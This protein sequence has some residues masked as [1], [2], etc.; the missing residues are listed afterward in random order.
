MISKNFFSVKD[1]LNSS[2]LNISSGTFRVLIDSMVENQND[3]ELQDWLFHSWRGNDE[4][5]LGP[6]VCFAHD[7]RNGNANG[8]VSSCKNFKLGASW[9]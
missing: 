4:C 8:F 9:S 3:F 5:T 2:L 6:G 7:I 1:G